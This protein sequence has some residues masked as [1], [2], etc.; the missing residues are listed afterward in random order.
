[1]KLLTKTIRAK[2]PALGRTDGQ[3]DSAVA[4]VKFF[5][6]VTD[7]RWFA[8]EFDSD[9][10]RF[11]GLVVCDGEAELGYFSL[12]ELQGAT[13]R[14]IPAIERDSGFR[15]TPLSKVREEYCRRTDGTS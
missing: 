11:F 3:G 2:L 4:Q 13:W 6:I 7:H 15:P 10:G 8:T 12:P 5:S 14:G 9:E 1:M